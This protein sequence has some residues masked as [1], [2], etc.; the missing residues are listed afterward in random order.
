M[1]EFEREKP[2]PADAEHHGNGTL[3]VHRDQLR[4]EWGRR[5]AAA[6]IEH[7]LDGA[8]DRLADL[9]GE[10]AARNPA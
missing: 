2:M 8:L 3:G 4:M 1:A 6:E 7:R 9:V 10:R 5:G